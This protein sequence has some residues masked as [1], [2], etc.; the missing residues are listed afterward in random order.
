MS[1]QPKLAEYLSRLPSSSEVRRK[2]AENLREAQLL[3]R[4]LKL[5][6]DRERV[7]EVRQREPRP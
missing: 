6:E 1:T 7:E 5:A 2:L 4:V 3:R